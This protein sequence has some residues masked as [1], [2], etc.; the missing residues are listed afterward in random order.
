MVLDGIRVVIFCFYPFLV[1]TDVEIIQ[2]D[3]T[4]GY[5]RMSVL[6]PC[7]QICVA[8]RTNTDPGIPTSAL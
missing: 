5:I 1:F 6:I 7:F 8:S 4:F 2:C 3:T